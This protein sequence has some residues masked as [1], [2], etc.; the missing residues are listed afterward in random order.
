MSMSKV[1]FTHS[2]FWVLE[3]PGDGL[4]QRLGDRADGWKRLGLVRK[5]GDEWILTEQDG[6][7]ARGASVE[8]VLKGRL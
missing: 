8:A 7:E 6:A 1:V 2:G 4:L 5:D 3:E